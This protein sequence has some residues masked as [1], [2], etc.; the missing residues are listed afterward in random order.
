MQLH[1]QYIFMCKGSEPP[2]RG[3]SQP[4]SAMSGQNMYEITMQISFTF[5]EKKVTIY[6]G[7]VV[8]VPFWLW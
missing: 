2:R 5:A 7:L 1:S 6:E 3:L 4:S 8:V